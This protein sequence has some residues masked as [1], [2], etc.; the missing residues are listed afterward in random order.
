MIKVEKSSEKMS[1]ADKCYIN[2][3][4]IL[5]DLVKKEKDTSLKL[6]RVMGSVYNDYPTCIKEVID[7]SI[8]KKILK[9]PVVKL[10]VYNKNFF[11][12]AYEAAEK[13][14]KEHGFKVILKK[15]YE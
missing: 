12:M 7:I 5:E 3:C 13:I 1:E 8:K 15:N 11:D 6:Y 2:A 4:D 9:S 10:D 14:E